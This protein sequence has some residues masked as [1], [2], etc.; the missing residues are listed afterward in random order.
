MAY[1]LGASELYLLG[2]SAVFLLIMLLL[3]R[4]IIPSIQDRLA[5][6]RQRADPPG[7]VAS[8]PAATLPGGMA[9]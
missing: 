8:A 6:R 3:P 7:A 5:S 1:K 9:P 2:Y 4:G